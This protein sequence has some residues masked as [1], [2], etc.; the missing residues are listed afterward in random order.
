[1]LGN[2]PDYYERLKASYGENFYQQEVLGKYLNLHAGRVY[3]AF[4]RA[5][6]VQECELDAAAPLLWSWDFNINPMASVICQRSGDVVYVLDEI[7]LETSSTPEVCDE[8]LSRYEKHRGGV[9]VYGDVSGNRS[10]TLTG[11]SDYDYIRKF[12]AERPELNGRVLV[13]VTNPQ[14]RDRLNL[15]NARLRNA[16]GEVRL[17]VHKKCRELIKDFEMVT[18]KPDS[19][20]IDKERDS[21]RTHLSDALG[22]LLYSEFGRLGP[23]GERGQRIM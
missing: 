1:L 19:G 15:V 6:H 11:T 5:T 13:A 20:Q 7:V 16:K 10:N 17:W 21:R 22:Y 8:F 3:Y 12:L 2:T 14:V 23:V 9:R 18:Y 4:E